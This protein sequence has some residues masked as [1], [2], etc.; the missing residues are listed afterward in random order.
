MPG[1]RL[2]TKKFIFDETVPPS[3]THSGIP[4]S[5]A[6]GM[7][8]LEDDELELPP[9]LLVD[10]PL[11]EELDGDAGVDSESLHAT[12]TPKMAVAI[13]TSA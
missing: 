10:P 3:P 4:E 7:S 1:F 2:V 13:G 9:L 12:R 11:L 5:P 6:S 8:P